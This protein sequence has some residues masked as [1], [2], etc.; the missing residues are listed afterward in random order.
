MESP[1]KDFTFEEPSLDVLTDFK[2][3]M[4]SDQ[5]HRICILGPSESGKTR[6]CFSLLEDVYLESSNSFVYVVYSQN[7]HTLKTW[8]AFFNFHNVEDNL[9]LI[10]GD[11]NDLKLKQFL[12]STQKV[13]S[14][15]KVRFFLIL[16]D[17]IGSTNNSSLEKKKQILNFIFYQGRHNGITS[18]FITQTIIALDARL[19]S[20]C[21]VT[22]LCQDESLTTLTDHTYSK[23][24][25]KAD[26]FMKRNNLL[27]NIKSR[28]SRI[29]TY[30]NL[31]TEVLDSDKYEALV[32]WKQRRKTRIAIIKDESK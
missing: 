4:N 11:E 30:Y 1:E 19:L 6:K 25:S 5:N 28:A 27:P 7:P 29:S 3:V 32:L 20:S 9:I 31:I 13:D 2:S 21:T 8:E 12:D 10:E 16:D 17:F 24:L 23:I 18:C 15:S 22:I 26:A 14:S